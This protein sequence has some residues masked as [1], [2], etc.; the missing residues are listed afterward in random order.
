MSIVVKKFGGTSVGDISRIKNVARLIRDFREQNPDTQVVAVVSAMA[1]E[2]NRLIALARSCVVNPDERELDVLSST[3][4]QVSVALLAMA[5]IELGLPAKSLLGQ[6]ARISTDSRH[7]NAQIQAIDDSTIR[8]TLQQGFI[9]VIAGFQ[10]I[11]ESGDVTT[12]G[13]GGSDISAVAVAAALKAQACYIYTDVEGVF[14][15]DP[16]VCPQARLIDRISHD[17]MLELASLGA[18]VLHPRS[19]FF[20]MRYGVPLVVLSTFKPGPG[21]WIVRES[22]LVENPVVTGITY[23]ADEARLTLHKLPGGIQSLSRV[24]D[25]LAKE[26]IFIDVISQSGIE[27]QLANVSFT[28]PDEVSSKALELA[29]ALVPQLGAEGA[30]IDRNISKVSVVGIGMRS[31]TGVAAKMF[32]ALAREQVDPQMI[33]TS[34]IKISVIIPRKYCEIAV[35]ALHESFIEMKPELGQES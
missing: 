18:K 28:V 34:D 25:A 24:F 13:R 5:L 35:R 30:S 21:T 7:T 9:P 29:Q 32:E 31:H 4:E 15:T 27:D 17:E 23:R 12:L 3:G 22:E 11:T 6:Q 19:V 33:S 16:R 1:G 2:T 20:A 10:G 14:S 8:A 26:E